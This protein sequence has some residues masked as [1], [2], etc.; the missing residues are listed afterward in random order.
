[1][2]E[3]HE[4]MALY[5]MLGLTAYIE[6]RL[7]LFEQTEGRKPTIVVVGALEWTVVLQN[8]PTD[9]WSVAGV[10]VIPDLSAVRLVRV[11]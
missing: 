1:M 6:E 7:K 4:F 3:P 10:P 11:Q 2:T 9:E 5:A 8:E